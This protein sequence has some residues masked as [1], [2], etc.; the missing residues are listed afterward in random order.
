MLYFILGFGLFMT[1]FPRILTEENAP[2][3]LSGFNTLSKDEQAQVDLRGLLKAMRDFHL[4]VGGISTLVALV[5][6][7]LNW[8]DAGMLTVTFGPI[9]GYFYLI[10]RMQNFYGTQNKSYQNQVK[11]GVSILAAVVIAVGILLGYGYQDNT[12]KITP[13]QLEFTGIYGLKIKKN[14]VV[15]MR[16]VDQLPEIT[17]RLNGFATQHMLK[18][19]FRDASGKKVHLI[20]NNRKGPYLEI[21][22]AKKPRVY[23]S[24][25][26]NARSVLQTLQSSGWSLAD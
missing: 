11:V 18:G 21:Q 20:L 19:K 7:F 4:K 8:K 14:Q 1:L 23:F 5:F 10:P 26:E 3:L 12:L 24:L 9:V 2:Q 13:D 16:Q 25:G 22:R 17:R 15:G 6:Y